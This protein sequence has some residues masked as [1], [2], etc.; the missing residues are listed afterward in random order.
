MC[1]WLAYT[2][3]PIL[4][5]DLLYRPEHSLIV[6]SMSSTMGAEATNGD[7]FGLG[8]Y[9]D[10]PTP[11]VFRSTEP[12]W[13]DRNLHELAS[14]ITSPCVLAHI[15]AST[16]SPVQETN[17]HPFRRGKW[18]WMHNGM[19]S[20]FHES[21]RDLAMAVDPSLYPD[22]EGSTDS[23]VFFYLALTF[24]LETDPIGA[25]SRA[26]GL[27]EEAGRRHGE[28][29]PMQMTIATTNGEGFYA[30]RYSSEGRS[31]SLFHS[32][33]VHTLRKQYP[34]NPM[35]QGVADD[36][37]MV[38]SEPL[39]SLQGAWLE[40]PESTCVVIRDGQQ[41][42]VPFAPTTLQSAV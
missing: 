19:I 20:G 25:V 34:D 42:Q 21:K 13:N 39:G 5:E 33:D 37:R 38:V 14:H 40:V 2:G 15:R 35:L 32:A 27:I 11:G 31:R 6:Q 17:C 36:A 1:R 8:W 23:E 10:R 41:E 29:F 4:V 18:L 24:G 12:A 26:V 9:G 7:G 28:M 22:I 16:G 30:F 3:S